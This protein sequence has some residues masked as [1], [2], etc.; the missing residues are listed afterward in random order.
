MLITSLPLDYIIDNNITIAYKMNGQKVSTWSFDDSTGVFSA[1]FSSS[2]EGAVEL[3]VGFVAFEVDQV[4]VSNARADV[5]S[6]QTVG[7]H[8]IWMSDGSDVAGASVDV[9]DA[10]YSTNETGVGQLR[11]KF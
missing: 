6:K 7:F 3:V 1:D 11:C 9:G 10:R 8:V 2:S 4:F 5:G